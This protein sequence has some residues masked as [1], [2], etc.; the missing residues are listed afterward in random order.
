MNMWTIRQLERD[1]DGINRVAK[2]LRHHVIVEGGVAGINKYK[3][4]LL[5]CYKIN[6]SIN[7]FPSF[8]LVQPF[9]YDYTTIYR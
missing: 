4:F 8:S 6:Q 3:L 5:D 7:T 1:R 2:G 9:F